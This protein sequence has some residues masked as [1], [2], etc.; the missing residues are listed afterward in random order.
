MHTDDAVFD[1]AAIAVVLSLHAHGVVAAL[2]RARLINASN[3]FGMRMLLGNNCMT[4]IAKLLFIPLNRF[5]K[6][7]E[8]PRFSIETQRHGFDAFSMLVG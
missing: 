5:K 6:P 8:R 7:L 3:R 4:T 2:G 1:L